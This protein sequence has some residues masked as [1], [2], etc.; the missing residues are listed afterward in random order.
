MTS[1]LKTMP[2][3]VLKNRCVALASLKQFSQRE[4]VPQAI[5]PVNHYCILCNKTTLNV[6]IDSVKYKIL[7]SREFYFSAYIIIVLGF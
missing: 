1:N 6:G 5:Y 7:C 3:S 4:H 2:Y